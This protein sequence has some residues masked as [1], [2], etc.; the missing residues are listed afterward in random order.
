MLFLHNDDN[1]PYI[2]NAMASMENKMKNF[3]IN[4]YGRQSLQTA[5]NTGPRKNIHLAIVLVNPQHAH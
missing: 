3:S 5:R 1:I 2:N 4:I